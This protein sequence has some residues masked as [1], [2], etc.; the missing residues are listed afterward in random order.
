MKFERIIYGVLLLFIGAVLLLDNFNVIEFYWRNVWSFWPVFLIIAGV[1]LLLNRNASQL[2]SKVSLG[3]LIITLIF[4]FFKGQENPR[5]QNWWSD[6]ND[7]IIDL[8]DNNDGEERVRK[9]GLHFSEPYLVADSAK[10]TIL[11]LSAG[12]TSFNLIEA[13][14]SLFEARVNKKSGNFSLIT[15]SSDS[16]K[17]ISFKMKN[18]RNGDRNTWSFNTGGNN[19]DISLNKLPLWELNIKMGAGEVD[20]DLADYK[21]R[22]LNFDGGA[23]DV[24]VKIG[25]RLPITD[26][27]VKTGVANVEIKIPTN[28]GCRIKSHTGLSSRDFKGFIKKSDGSYETPNYKESKNKIFINLDGGLS[29][30]EVDTY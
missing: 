27:N 14:D 8:D 17:T 30:F 29:N 10:T 26:V 9:N 5:N 1:K 21:V 18:K 6:R 24:S 4:L 12:G 7:I 3:I 2:G 28:S 16:T 23:A 20:F 19:V 11:N 25:E 22:E 15:S 13:T